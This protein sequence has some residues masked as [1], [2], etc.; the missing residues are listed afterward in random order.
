A[1]S[2]LDALFYSD[3]VSAIGHRPDDDKTR[4][5]AVNWDADEESELDKQIS[6]VITDALDAGDDMDEIAVYCRIFPETV[7]YQPELTDIEKQNRN[8]N[9]MPEIEIEINAETGESQTIVNGIA[10]PSC[11]KTAEAI[12]NVFG[13]P[14]LDEKTREYHIQPQV[15]RQIKGK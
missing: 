9:F 2:F 12:K 10:G 13:K 14:T 3:S 6:Q 5:V 8:Q 1:R 4:A 11:E 7:L 15:R